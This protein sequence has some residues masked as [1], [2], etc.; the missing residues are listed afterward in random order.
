MSGPLLR[1]NLRGSRTIWIIMTFVFC[2]YFSV[3]VA[4]YDPEGA[5]ALVDMLKLLPEALVNA[6]AFDLSGTTIIS[7][8]AGSMYGA[9]MFLFPLVI[10]ITVNHG[11][12]AT[13]V[14]R[15]SMA[16]LLATPISRARFA[17]TQAV[18]SIL[19]ITLFFTVVTGFGIASIQ[20]SWPGELELGKFVLLNLYALTMY[21]AI[22]GIGFVAS[23]IAS[24]V[25]HSLSLGVGIPIAFL[26]LQMVGN[27]SDKYGW[28]G[29][30]SL[31]ELFDPF[32][33]VAGSTE[34]YLRMAILVGIAA[35]LYAAGL[36]YFGRRDL[37]V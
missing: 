13:H 26:M 28:I 34:V 33:V 29:K 21:W 27:A 22:G 11:L 24:E 15:G 19:S 36:I 37:H 25:R 12:I 10:S 20:A 1:V 3:M 32:A 4:M 6:I 9:L 7:F 35:A 16:F 17:R 30:L 2:W 23:A 18:F 31:Y 14:D 5:Q 8:L